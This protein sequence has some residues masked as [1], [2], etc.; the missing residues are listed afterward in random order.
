MASERDNPAS[1]T[2]AKLEAA[3]QVRLV[4]IDPDDSRYFDLLSMA[5]ATNWRA[6]RIARM[7]GMS[8]AFVDR[9]R[10]DDL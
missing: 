1:P 2:T 3:K 8:D 9:L 6:W 5:Y 10:S 4:E 7:L